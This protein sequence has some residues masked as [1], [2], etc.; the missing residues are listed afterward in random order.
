[1]SRTIDRKEAGVT[2]SVAAQVGVLVAAGILSKAL[3]EGVSSLATNA[4]RAANMR[5]YWEKIK[6]QYPDELGGEDAEKN[7]QNFEAIYKIAP[8]IAKIPQI[9]IH[10]LR[11]ARD[12]STGGFDP[13]TIE[14][15]ARTE[16]SVGDSRRSKSA[17]VKE[18][19]LDA[20]TIGEMYSPSSIDM[21]TLPIGFQGLM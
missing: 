15:L 12:Y 20:K 5:R 8:T 2:S 9:S 10:Y 19:S 21:A 16:A 6:N 14:T 1:M 13:S 17:P 11:Q 7:K 3:Y 4:D 18:V